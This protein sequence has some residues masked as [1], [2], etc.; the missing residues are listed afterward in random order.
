[1]ANEL[2]ENDSQEEPAPAKDAAKDGVLVDPESVSA[3]K[4]AL[5]RLLSD[6]EEA[7]RIGEAGRRRVENEFTLAS[8]AE[9]ILRAMT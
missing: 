4:E 1:M 7:S 5:S 9:K 2:Q 8:R 6:R 3:V